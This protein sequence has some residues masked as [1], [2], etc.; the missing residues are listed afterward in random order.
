MGVITEDI[1]ST[2]ARRML[3]TD[4]A[5]ITARF[6]DADSFRYIC[7]CL[8][9]CVFLCVCIFMYVCMYM[10]I[11]MYTY[12]YTYVCIYVYMYICIHVYMYIYI[13]VYYIYIHA[14]NKD[15]STH[16]MYIIYT[17]AFLLLS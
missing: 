3:L 2:Y 13:Y 15:I 17:H 5:W 16:H 7:G 9:V 14:S 10:Y 4:L 8:Y 11:Y 1:L 12:I 6:S